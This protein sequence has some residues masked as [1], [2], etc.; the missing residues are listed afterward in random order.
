MAWSW[1]ISVILGA[2]VVGGV[3]ALLVTDRDPGHTPTVLVTA[4]LAVVVALIT[5][6][7]T[8][9]RQERQLEHEQRSVER[10]L[11]SEAQ[12][13]VIRIRHERAVHDLEE[14][15]ALLDEAVNAARA[16]NDHDVLQS[17]IAASYGEKD[18]NDAYF[19][20]A[21]R[22]MSAV[23]CTNRLQIRLGRQHPLS[24]GYRNAVTDLSDAMSTWRQ[25]AGSERDHKKL[26]T[27][28]NDASSSFSQAILECIDIASRIVGTAEEV[29][30][31]TDQRPSENEPRPS[32]VTGPDLDRAAAAPVAGRTDEQT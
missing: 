22:A 16:L 30:S 10:Q 4:L 24:E 23:T 6:R 5:A 18:A 25:T 29:V 12:R 1:R 13:L 2:L 21:P 9:R 28:I 31:V 17:M 20:W 15:R 11:A 27:I 7:T 14:L 26:E 19:E 8:D 32:Q 3:S